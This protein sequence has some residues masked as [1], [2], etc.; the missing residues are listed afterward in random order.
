[1]SE[2]EIIAEIKAESSIKLSISEGLEREIY[3]SSLKQVVQ[4]LNTTLPPLEESADSELLEKLEEKKLKKREE[5]KS[6]FKLRK[7]EEQLDKDS[8]LLKSVTP[9][10]NI[11]KCAKKEVKVEKESRKKRM[12]S[13]SERKNND[14]KAN[15]KLHSKKK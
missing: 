7:E 8:Y 13:F 6:S 12:N 10:R 15:R 2:N 3:R 4:F 1:M 14:V 5:R 11:E 9:R